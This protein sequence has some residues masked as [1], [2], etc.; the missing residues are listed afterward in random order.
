MAFKRIGYDIKKLKC[1][2]VTGT[3]GKGS[4]CW[5]IFKALSSI[6]LK[7]G[8]YTSPHINSYR[9]RIRVNDCL[10]SVEDVIRELKFLLN[11]SETI[12]LGFFEITTMLAFKYFI[13]N[14]VDIAIIEVGIGG[15]LDSTNLVDPL[16]SIITS[17]GLDHLKNLGPTI[18]DV[19]YAKSG[20]IKLN[21]PVVLGPT[22]NMEI[23]KKIA[24]EMNSQVIRNTERDIRNFDFINSRTSELA[25]EY[26]RSEYYPELTNDV[27]KN[28]ISQRPIC[29]IEKV[30]FC[31]INFIMDCAHNPPA[32]EALFNTLDVTE[33]YHICITFSNDKDIEGC[34]KLVLSKFKVENI[35]IFAPPYARSVDPILLINIINKQNPLFKL[36]TKVLSAKEMVQFAIN[37]FPE[38][39]NVVICGTMYILG[40]IR[41]ELKLDIIKP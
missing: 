17:I 35:H 23:I 6:G 34:V 21:K 28:G 41:E 33:D 20:I 22:A 14:N 7:V 26:M 9:E 19:A 13:D 11:F 24:N 30:N 15:R 32:L 8:L 40:S 4:V 2:H 16:L 31:K 12:S 27:I 1:I 3:N 36:D 25:L 37:N 29:R 10:I 39:T 18:N 38:E 5:K